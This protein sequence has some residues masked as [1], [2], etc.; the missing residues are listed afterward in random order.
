MGHVLGDPGHAVDLALG[1]LD[2]EGAHPNPANPAV[3]V[4]YAVFQIDGPARQ[5]LLVESG[6]NRS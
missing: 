5:A 2:R 3:R 4:G 1:I 6:G